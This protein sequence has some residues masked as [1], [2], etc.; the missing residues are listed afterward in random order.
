MGDVISRMQIV[1]INTDSHSL[2]V[3]GDMG[4]VISRMQIVRINTDSHSLHVVVRNGRCDIT[5]ADCKD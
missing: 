1:R 3:V 5:Y 4:D 2:H